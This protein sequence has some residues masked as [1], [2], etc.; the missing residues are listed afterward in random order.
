MD[1]EKCYETGEYDG[2]YCEMCPH[3]FECSGYED[4]D[5]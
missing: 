5:E 2:E 4:E 1:Y 3:K